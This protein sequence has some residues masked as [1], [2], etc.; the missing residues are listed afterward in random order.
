MS[1]YLI[2]RSR[3]RSG[4][5]ELEIIGAADVFDKPAQGWLLK[6]YGVIPVHRGDYDRIC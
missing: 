1:Q 6:G 2:R 4:Q 5:N 3:L